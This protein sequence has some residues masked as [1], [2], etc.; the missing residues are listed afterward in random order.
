MMMD[1]GCLE[2]VVNSKPDTLIK[3]LRPVAALLAVCF[4]LLGVLGMLPLILVGIAFGGLFYFAN[5]NS[6]VD[7]EYAYVE[8]ELRIARILQKSKR[9]E[10]ATYD[11]TKMTLLAPMNSPRF[12]GYRNTEGT[13]LDYSSRVAQQPDTRYCLVM[14]DRTKVILQL[15]SEYG[16]QLVDAI[17]R[18]SPSSVVKQTV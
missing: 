16:M 1:T 2:V 8:G 15:D 9:K 4:V 6:V 14:S 13:V 11:L 17:Y 12:D 10:V 18:F 5:L 3:V 7:Y